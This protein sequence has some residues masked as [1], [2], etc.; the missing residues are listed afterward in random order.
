M[1]GLET[2]RGRE[3]RGEEGR[4]G[5]GEGRRGG[6]REG[7]DKIRRRFGAKA[8]SAGWVA[9]GVEKKNMQKPGAESRRA[10]VG[11]LHGT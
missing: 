1:E 7:G 11:A 6:G 5:E 4:E 3:R 9:E 10:L 2:K 8:H